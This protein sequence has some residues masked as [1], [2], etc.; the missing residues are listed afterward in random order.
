MGLLRFDIRYPNGERDIAVVEGERAVVGSASHCDVRLPV[1]QAAYEHLI[2]EVSGGSV[3]AEA[4]ATNPP[5]TI[6]G[7]P[8]TSS[9]VGPDAALGAGNVRIF[10]SYGADGAETDAAL[11]KEK[12]KE[13]SPIVRVAALV[14][15]P[16]AGYMLLLDPNDGLA[17][18][19]ADDP[20]L[21]SSV[22]ATCPQ[23]TREQ[24]IM[25]GE[26]KMDQATGKRERTPFSPSEGLEAVGLYETAAACLKLGGRVDQAEDAT[27]AATQLREVIT[28][29]MRTRR[30][31]LVRMLAVEDYQLADRDVKALEGLTHGKQGA[32]VNW[33]SRV[34]SEL[35]A[36]KSTPR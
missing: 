15:I 3:R 19:P 21:F 27:Q 2:I 6:N 5:A 20:V 13:T 35:N 18:P 17:G 25:A 32:F 1:D 31:R 11:A 7:M 22:A 26:E 24:A 9:A 8:L 30:L 12:K 14:A 16:I 29:D 28:R 23:T 34:R 4:R 10:V 36:K 33:L